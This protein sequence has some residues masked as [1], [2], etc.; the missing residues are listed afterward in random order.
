MSRRP[1]PAASRLRKIPL[2]GQPPGA[3]PET[4]AP[5]QAP[6]N[7]YPRRAF[8]G[9]P[10]GATSRRRL[11]TYLAFILIKNTK[12]SVNRKFTLVTGR[13]D[14]PF[15]EGNETPL[16][17]TAVRQPDPGKHA[18]SWKKAEGQTFR[19]HPERGYGGHKKRLAMP[20]QELVSP[21]AAP[22][23]SCVQECG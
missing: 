6:S 19:P 22:P 13:P 18:Q 1:L 14:R 21:R 7:A 4:A 12:Y 23:T 8:S 11:I 2:P 3:V 20:R 17:A 16:P 9:A 15:R 10:V 5:T